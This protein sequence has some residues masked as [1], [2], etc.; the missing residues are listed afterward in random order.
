M[1][2]IA[3]ILSEIYAGHDKRTTDIRDMN[4][5]VNITINHLTLK[6]ERLNAQKPRE[7]VQTR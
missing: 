7:E 2:L 4:G 1:D 6:V 5:V 3:S